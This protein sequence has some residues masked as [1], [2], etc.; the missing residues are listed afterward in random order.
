[1][2]DRCIISSSSSS[3][4]RLT[5]LIDIYVVIACSVDVSGGRSLRS[6][7]AD[8]V[9]MQKVAPNLS[10]TCTDHLDATSVRSISACNAC[11]RAH[12]SEFLCL[13]SQ[14]TLDSSFG[15]AQCFFPQ[16]IIDSIKTPI[17]L[18]NAAYDVWQVNLFARMNGLR[19]IGD[20]KSE[21]FHMELTKIQS[22]L[23]K[24]LTKYLNSC[25]L[26]KWMKYFN[27]N[28]DPIIVLKN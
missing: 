23:W 4:T 7:Y 26:L 13:K 12:S 19:W 25:E 6:Y 27:K 16:N 5:W 3:R 8:I 9:Y 14:L 28:V 20:Q 15:C 18:L 17:F 1:V 24:I 11:W 21:N 2:L 10:P 22:K